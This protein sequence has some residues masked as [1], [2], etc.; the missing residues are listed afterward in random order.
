VPVVVRIIHSACEDG[1]MTGTRTKHG[2]FTDEKEDGM[3]GAPRNGLNYLVPE[4]RLELSR[5]YPQPD[6]IAYSPMVPHTNGITL[7]RVPI[8]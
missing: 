6:F 5:G 8:P 7:E 1:Q 2:Q 4:E 3:I